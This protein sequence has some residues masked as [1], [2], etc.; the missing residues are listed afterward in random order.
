ME[1]AAL[2][3]Q[4]CFRFRHRRADGS[5]REVEVFS[6]KI[7]IAGK[8]FLYSSVHDIT[9]R[10]LAENALLERTA[11]LA[12]A[13]SKLEHEKRLLAAVMEA[14]PTGVAITDTS[15]GVLLANEAYERIWS[16]PRPATRSV[17][18]YTAYKAWQAE[19]GEVVA[20]EEWASARALQTGESTVGQILR[21]QRFD[22]SVAFVINSA[23]PVYDAGGRIVGSA[24][25]IQDIT[26]LKR[27][28]HA[29]S[30]SE[31]LLRIFIEHAPAAL[32]M[33]DRDMRYLSVSSRWLSDYGLGNRDLRGLSHYEVFPEIPAHWK[34][35]HRRGLAGE[36]LQEEDDS[37]KR[38]DG[39][40]QWGRWEI[41]P[42][43]EASGA[44]GG[45]ILFTED[46]TERKL[47]ED[48]LRNRNKD[49]ETFNYA[50]VGRELRMIELKQEINEL[51]AV[52]GKPPRYALDF[53]N[54]NGV[55]NDQ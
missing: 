9:E 45:I 37:F 13:K 28:E 41:H 16:G 53:L 25:A 40:V 36:V 1:K 51:C 55:S 6:N 48:E 14:L 17:A 23:S 49:L 38:I 42:W 7:E 19:T 52:A 30:E 34:E 31:Q 32:A 15:G 2:S 21:I 24:V 39:S 12:S 50:A 10:V 35:M 11:E 26:E 18:D 47:A 27:I 20:P 33:F 8:A 29:L 46:T 3:K 43:Y 54:E 44:I 4:N 22:G 5:I